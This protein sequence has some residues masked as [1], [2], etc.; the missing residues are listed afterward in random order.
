MNYIL[1]ILAI[2]FLFFIFT[3][4]KNSK[5]ISISESFNTDTNTD[6]KNVLINMFLSK[7]CP[8]CVSYQQEHNNIEQKVKNIFPNAKFN[9]IFS[10]QNREIFEE[11]NIEYV[12]AC[13]INVNNTG[14]KKM[15]N[16]INEQNIINFIKNN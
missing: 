8:H 11:N 1:I 5:S 3:N 6:N 15:N 2:A 10:D 9:I 13:M 12:P 16:R 7:S 14:Y 4:L